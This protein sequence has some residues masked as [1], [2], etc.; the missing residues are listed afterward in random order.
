[1][2]AIAISFA[3]FEPG[4]NRPTSLLFA[5]DIGSQDDYLS[6]Y[7]FKIKHVALNA[8]FGLEAVLEANRPS[9]GRFVRARLRGDDG[10]EDVLQDLWI[11]V[12]RLDSGPIGEPL[13]YLYRIAENLI[14][15]RKRAGG[16][17]NARDRA[18]AEGQIDGTLQAPADAAPNA[19]RALIARDMLR[20]VDARLDALPE[21]TAFTFR[22]VRVQGR[23]QKD[24]AAELGISVS[25]V[26]KHLQRA[27]REIVAVSEELNADYGEPCRLLPEGVSHDV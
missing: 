5:H 13:A 19:E 3:W 6:S 14:L 24:L 8:P 25:A 9:L 23:P 10:A 21:R 16:R 17:R 18:W 22:A 12:S 7:D 1:M 27:Y 26:E 20:R 4:L 2:N 15:D 11:K